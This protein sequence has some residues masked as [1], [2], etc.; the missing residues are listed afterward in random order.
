VSKSKQLRESFTLADSELDPSK[1]GISE[2]LVIGLEPNLVIFS[3]KGT[4][5]NPQLIQLTPVLKA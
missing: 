5:L 4:D 1:E 3:L 2:K